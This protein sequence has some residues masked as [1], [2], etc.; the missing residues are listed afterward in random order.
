MFSVLSSTV[1]LWT[2]WTV[3]SKEEGERLQKK[4]MNAA[5]I[6]LG[7]DNVALIAAVA[8]TILIFKGVITCTPAASWGLVGATTVLGI[9]TLASDITILRHVKQKWDQNRLLKIA[10]A[11]WAQNN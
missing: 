3:N 11:A 5:R 6:G 10:E 8:V 4:T 9:V 1:A 2:K 7:L